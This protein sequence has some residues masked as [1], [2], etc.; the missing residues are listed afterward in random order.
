M[1]DSMTLIL[2][3]LVEDVLIFVENMVGGE[4]NFLGVS[5]GEDIPYI[6]CTTCS[7]GSMGNYMAT[8]VDHLFLYDVDHMFGWSTWSMPLMS[9][10]EEPFYELPIW[11]VVHFLWM[12]AWR[13]KAFI[14]DEIPH[15]FHH[16]YLEK[17]MDQ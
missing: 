5:L 3:P 16:F 2:I 14:D 15:D 7:K 12:I 17:A 13:W 11:E 10:C 4:I 6:F 9:H 1:A 8:I